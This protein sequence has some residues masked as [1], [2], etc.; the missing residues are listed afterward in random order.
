MVCENS[1]NKVDKTTDKEKDKIAELLQKETD[2]IS[3]LSY[4]NVHDLLHSKKIAQ[5]INQYHTKK[6]PEFQKILDKY[7]H[8]L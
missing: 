2:N 5:I 3:K 1:N 8:E 6:T 4:E 7:L